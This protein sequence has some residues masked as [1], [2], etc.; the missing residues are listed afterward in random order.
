MKFPFVFQSFFSLVWPNLFM[1]RIV[2]FHFIFLDVSGCL[3]TQRK[4]PVSKPVLFLCLPCCVQAGSCF[5]LQQAPYC[6]DEPRR[7][8]GFHVRTW[9]SWQ[10]STCLCYLKWTVF[11]N[12]KCCSSAHWFIWGTGERLQIFLTATKSNKR[13]DL[14]MFLKANWTVA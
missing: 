13:V 1:Q 4:L 8:L 11:Y 9:A 5:L 3:P 10:H 14:C 7:V 2:L 6:C 12:E